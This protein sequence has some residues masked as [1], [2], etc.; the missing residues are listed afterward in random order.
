MIFLFSDSLLDPTLP[1][2]LCPAPSTPPPRFLLQL[3]LSGTD[4]GA[5]VLDVVETNPFRHLTHLSLK[6]IPA[7]DTYLKKYLAECLTNLKVCACVCVCV[8]VRAG[9]YVC[10][11]VNTTCYARAVD[12]EADL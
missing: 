5:S 8:C 3:H 4:K 1:H 7:G 6:L 12:S 2:P 9:L 11:P 10:I